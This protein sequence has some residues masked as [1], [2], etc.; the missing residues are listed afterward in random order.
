M[1]KKARDHLWNFSGQ[2]GAALIGAFALIAG[3][4]ITIIFVGNPLEKG[5][6]PPQPSVTNTMDVAQKS[7]P[8]PAVA[9]PNPQPAPSPKSANPSPRPVTPT[10]ESVARAAPVAAAPPQT[11]IKQACVVDNSVI[12]APTTQDCTGVTQ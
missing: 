1:A 3:A 6:Q 8:A 4:V 5:P 7:P 10:R 2:I 11:I 12:E 9:P